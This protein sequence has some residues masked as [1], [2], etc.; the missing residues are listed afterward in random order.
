MVSPRTMCTS[1]ANNFL[2]RSAWIEDHLK[3]QGANR[4]S[5]LRPTPILI[6]GSHDERPPVLTGHKPIRPSPH[7]GVPKLFLPDLGEVLRRQDVQAGQDIRQRG[8]GTMGM[9]A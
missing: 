1:P 3:G 6:V 5:P 4:R 2:K 9:E 8:D 7:W